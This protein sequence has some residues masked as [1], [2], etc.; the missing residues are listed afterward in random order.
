MLIKHFIYEYC[1]NL[2][3]DNI[4]K[5][6]NSIKKYNVGDKYNKLYCY[7][8]ADEYYEMTGIDVTDTYLHIDTEYINVEIEY[9]TD[10]SIKFKYESYETTYIYKTGEINT[11]IHNTD[12]WTIFGLSLLEGRWR[13]T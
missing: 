5:N 2:L 8:S 12:S 13:L 3:F 9:V 7:C 10:Y 1:I 6:F 4:S 11:E